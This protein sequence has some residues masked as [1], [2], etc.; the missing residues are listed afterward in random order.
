[1]YRKTQTIFAAIALIAVCLF[2]KLRLKT[3]HTK[4][5]RLLIMQFRQ[6]AIRQN[7]NN[8]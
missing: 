7:Q 1:M 8:C 3:Q 4:S 2:L 6:K 5:K